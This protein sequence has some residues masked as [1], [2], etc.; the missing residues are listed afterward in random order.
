ML[1]LR[2]NAALKKKGLSILSHYIESAALYFALISSLKETKKLF[3]NKVHHSVC[4][5]IKKRLSQ[6]SFKKAFK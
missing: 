3:L 4:K 5:S 6:K 1:T 2:K